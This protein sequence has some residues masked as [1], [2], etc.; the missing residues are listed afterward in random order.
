M[1]VVLDT[2]ETFNDLRLD[3]PN[4]KLLRTYL[5]DTSSQVALPY[6]V[7]EETSNHFRVKLSKAIKS[8]KDSVCEIE[9]LTGE[10]LLAVSGLEFDEEAALQKFR[11]HVEAQLKTLNGKIVGCEA[12]DVKA[13]VARSLLRRKPFDGEG[14]KGFRDAILWETV[15]REVLEKNAANVQVALVTQN[16][17]DFGKDEVLADDLQ[18]DCKAIGRSE[19]CVR[20]FNGLKR[21]VDVEV[22]PHLDKLNA[23]H[24]QIQEGRYKDFDAIEMFA[25]NHYSIHDTVRDWLRCCDFDRVTRQAVGH[26]RSPDL[27]SLEMIP[28][29]YEVVDV[30]SI[31]KDQVAV[32]ID[33]KVDGE[34]T[35]LE[36]REEYYPSGDEVFSEWFEI[37]YVGDATFKVS[38]TVILDKNSGGSQDFEINDLEVTLGVKWPYHDDDD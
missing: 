20:L 3:G 29:E 35:C 4:F 22:K 25:N 8:H 15:L 21:F 33:Y 24:E 11:S 18:K 27:H 9:K 28:F 16:S 17:N 12:V 10:P 31:E 19:N 26:F 7:F 1:I 36:Q 38:M 14:H 32:G 30:W 13:L 34:I 6:V 5:H 37:E 23:I 2:T